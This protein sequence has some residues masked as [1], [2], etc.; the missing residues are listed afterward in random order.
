MVA[1]AEE[2]GSHVKGK[3]VSCQL[4]EP[5]SCLSVHFNDLN[6]IAAASETESRCQTAQSG[7]Y[8][9]HFLSAH[10]IILFFSP[11]PEAVHP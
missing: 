1:H 10:T 3:A 5:P 4:V 6:L 11:P 8:Y 7:T 2:G 9:Q